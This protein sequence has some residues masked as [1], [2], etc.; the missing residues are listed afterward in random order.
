MLN[1]LDQM[2]SRKADTIVITDCPDKVEAHF[3]SSLS[4]FRMRR[5]GLM[6]KYEQDKTQL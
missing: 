6:K 3:Q 1:A 5:D 2:K 4:K